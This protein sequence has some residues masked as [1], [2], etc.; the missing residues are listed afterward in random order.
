MKRVFIV[1]Q[2]MAGAEGDWRP[3]LKSELEKRGYEVSVPDMPDIDTPVIEKWVGHLAN[4]VGVP[5]KDTYCIGSD[6]YCTL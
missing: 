5:D 6:T 3:W 1:H 4:M 2:W